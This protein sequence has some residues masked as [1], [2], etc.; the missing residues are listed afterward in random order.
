MTEKIKLIAAGG[1]QLIPLPDEYRF[2][3]EEVFIRRDPDSGDVILSSEPASWE[4]F[5]ASFAAEE[6]PADFMSPEDRQQG[7]SRDDPLSLESV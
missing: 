5:F 6:I 7:Q 1:C 4:D 3:G 2:L